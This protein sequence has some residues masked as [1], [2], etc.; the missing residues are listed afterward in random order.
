MRPALRVEMSDFEHVWGTIQ[1]TLLHPFENNLYHYIPIL[2]AFTWGH[3]P[4][5]QSDYGQGSMIPKDPAQKF[6]DEVETLR[7]CAGLS[8]M[9]DLYTSLIFHFTS[10]GGKLSCTNPIIV[11]PYHRLF[12]PDGSAF[13]NEGD[14]TALAKDIH[15]LTDDETRFYIAREIAHIKFGDVFFI[16]AARVAFI[17]T[18]CFLY[19]A[20]LSWAGMIGVATG[21]IGMVLLIERIHEYAI[22]RFAIKTLGIA[23]AD[24]KRA[25]DAALSSLEKEREK[26]MERRRENRFCQFYLT[27]SGDNLLDIRHPFLSSRINELVEKIKRPQLPKQRCPIPEQKPA[28]RLN[29]C[30]PE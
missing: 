16:T 28:Q 5:V 18:L 26:N 25:I 4:I 9:I 3:T 27:P 19:A 12:R 8:K 2:G 20:S 23:L 15:A 13:C 14:Q 7:K 6:F 24:P 10:F 1:N 22:D 11:I 29:N 30:M 21:A 17:A